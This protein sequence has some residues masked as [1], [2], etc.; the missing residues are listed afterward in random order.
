[1]SERILNFVLE[2]GAR[3]PRSDPPGLDGES[4][5]GSCCSLSPVL[6][7]KAKEFTSLEFWSVLAF[8]ILLFQ[9]PR[10]RFVIA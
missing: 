1:M 9:F 5:L 4:F 8:L 7:R 3:D 6:Q 10:E 2:R